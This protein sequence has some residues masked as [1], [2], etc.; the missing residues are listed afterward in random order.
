[1]QQDFE[2]AFRI[3]LGVLAVF[4]FF[5]RQFYIRRFRAREK[6]H[7]RHQQHAVRGYRMLYVANFGVIFFVF[8]L[9]VGFAQLPLPALLRWSGA[10]AMVAALALYAWTHHTLGHVWSGVL[11]ISEGHTLRTEGPYR[12]VRH[13]MYSAFFLYAVGVLLLSANAAVGGVLL[14]ATVLMY[15]TRIDAEEQM[16]LDQFGDEYREYMLRAGRL[17]PRVAR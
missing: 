6:V 12:F 4:Y 1:M 9:G 13:P 7:A 2:L 16:L 17:L 5:L 3:V 10:G 14:V 11:E 8:D 15:V